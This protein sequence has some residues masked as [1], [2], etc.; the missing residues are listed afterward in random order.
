MYP[1]SEKG[2]EQGGGHDP[3]VGRGGAP[4]LEV[5]RVRDLSLEV[6]GAGQG[7]DHGLGL[8]LCI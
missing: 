5:G 7:P 4:D 3:E 2:V 8:L 6:G 1:W